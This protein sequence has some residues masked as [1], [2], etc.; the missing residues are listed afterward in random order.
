MKKILLIT[1]ITIFVLAACKKTENDSV[2]SVNGT[3]SG[4]LN[5]LSSVGLPL[6][7]SGDRTATAVVTGKENNQLEV[8]CLGDE[9]DTTFMLNSYQYHDSLMVCLTGN[10]FNDMYGHMLG[11]GHMSGGMMGDR[12]NNET[13][14]EHHMN[15]EHMDR[16]E[17]FGGFDMIKNTFLYKFK[18]TEGDSIY[19][20]KFTGMKQ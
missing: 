10:D 1:A 9:L 16:D 14:W 6:E 20:L 7:L 13:D 17:H 4:T 11:Q 8:H 19:Y 5:R 18:M 12:G 2:V 15:D 3:Y